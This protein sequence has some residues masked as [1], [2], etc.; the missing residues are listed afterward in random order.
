MAT[1]LDTAHLDATTTALVAEADALASQSRESARTSREVGETYHPRDTAFRFTRLAAA[2]GHELRAPLNAIVG[3]VSLLERDVLV[4]S[5]ARIHLDR[6]SRSSRHL[7]T[8]LDDVLALSRLDSGQ[9]T[10]SCA[11]QRL[12]EAID[13]ALAD[14]ELHARDRRVVIVNAV[15]NVTAGPCYWGDEQRV[16]QILVNL[17][18][19][20][21]K[22]TAPAGRIT[23]SGG[24]SGPTSIDDQ[25]PW[26]YVSVDDTGRGIP[27]EQIEMIFEPFR[28]VAPSDQDCGTGLGLS[29]SRQLARAMGGD[30]TVSSRL[31]AGSR[32]TLWLCTPPADLA[33]GMVGIGGEEASNG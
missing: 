18:T 32:F 7:L 20:A 25:R 22:F 31:G 6:L 12:R 16:R 30:I 13:E 8:M 5:T 4:G 27:K 29:I 24:T 9:F 10:M 14:V 19:N 3:T 2:L 17:L 33:S 23:I 15:S 26:T 21:I 11:T 28:Q 1:V